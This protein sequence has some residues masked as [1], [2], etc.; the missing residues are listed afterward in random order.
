MFYHNLNLS[1][2]V[3]ILSC[4]ILHADCIQWKTYGDGEEQNLIS[5]PYI[6]SYPADFIV[7]PRSSWGD[8]KR[9]RNPQIRTLEHLMILHNPEQ[10]LSIAAC[11][12]NMIWLVSQPTEIRDM[13]KFFDKIHF[14]DIKQDYTLVF[15]EYTPSHKAFA[16]YFDIPDENGCISFQSLTF[17]FRKGTTYYDHKQIIDEIINRFIPIYAR[18]RERKKQLKTEIPP[19]ECL[20]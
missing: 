9:P 5:S 17:Y 4:C 3:N 7:D 11:E 6:I 12:Y 19:N 10:T 1:I 13:M 2:F 14:I 20:E 15:T 18:I 8:V 16:F